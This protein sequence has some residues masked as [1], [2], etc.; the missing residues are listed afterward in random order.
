LVGYPDVVLQ[1]PK[2]LE[3]VQQVPNR[4]LMV[5]NTNKRNL[6]VILYFKFGSSPNPLAVVLNP[7]VV[8]GRPEQDEDVQ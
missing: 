6:P 8:G 5:K 1:S 4:D 2:L 3:V 7:K